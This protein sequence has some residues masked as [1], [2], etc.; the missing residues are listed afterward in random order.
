MHITKGDDMLHIIA[1]L[2]DSVRK[3]YISNQAQMGVDQ[4]AFTKRL[5]Q[6]RGFPQKVHFYP[7]NRSEDRLDRTIGSKRFIWHPGLLDAHL[8][9]P[10]FTRQNWLRLR[11]L[12]VHFLNEEQMKWVDAYTERFCRLVFCTNN[13][14]EGNELA[15]FHWKI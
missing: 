15:Y 8:I 3:G 4:R 1:G 14:I 5:Y 12:A 10:G 9:R 13:A 11:Q 6:W 2:R 7:H